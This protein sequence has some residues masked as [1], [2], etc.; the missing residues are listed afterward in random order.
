[1]LIPQMDEGIAIINTFAITLRS[2][3]FKNQGLKN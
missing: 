3:Y 1:M 2:V